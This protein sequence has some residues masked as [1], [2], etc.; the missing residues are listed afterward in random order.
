M[1]D[2]SQFDPRC[3]TFSQSQALEPV[4][5]RLRLGEVPSEV[6]TRLWNT[7]YTEIRAAIPDQVFAYNTRCISGSWTIIIQEILDSF[8]HIS[9]DEILALDR[10][11]RH[12]GV[13]IDITVSE[14]KFFFLAARYHK[15][16]DL[17]Q[18]IMRHPKRPQEYVQRISDIFEECQM[19]Y[20]VDAN[21]PPTIYPAVT[22]QEAAAITT[23]R[24]TLRAARQGAANR[25]LQRATEL[26]GE[27]NWAESVHESIN[28]VESVAIGLVKSARTLGDALKQLNGRGDEPN[29]HPALIASLHKLYGYRGNAPGVGH[30]ATDDGATV[31]QEEAVLLLCTCASYCT[32]L[33]SKARKSGRLTP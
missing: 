3:L 7:L 9:I 15:V 8:F 29:V 23:A 32:F 2:G 27:R 30:A 1:D 10:F 6:R 22:A 17:L 18:C 5:T 28:A 20:V 25:H 21:G 12:V 24:R 33:L 14:F 31:G 13:K 11:D 16:F 26:L 19:A 4:P